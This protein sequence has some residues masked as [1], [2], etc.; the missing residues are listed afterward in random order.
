MSEGAV[1][2]SSSMNFWARPALVAA[3][4]SGLALSSPH[5]P[6]PPAFADPLL[7]FLVVAVVLGATSGPRDGVRPAVLAVLVVC[8]AV[9]LAVVDR[10][11]LA[12][13]TL[14]LQTLALLVGARAIGRAVGE[15]IASAGHVLPAAIIAAAADVASVL[16][17]EGPTAQIVASERAVSL[18]VLAV[19]VPGTAEIAPLLGVGDVVF[20]ALLFGVVAR[21]ELS[22]VRTAVASALGVLA[23]FGLSLATASAVPALPTIGAAALL[24]EPRFRTLAPRDRRTAWIGI[25]L[26]IFV[27]AVVALRAKLSSG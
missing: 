27:V 14:A 21:H 9:A 25:G 2:G 4:A 26:A 19:P 8:A 24:F 6:V 18:L 12:T 10:V 1:S 23:A 22:A 11:G 16:S 17:P 3:L 5:V 13:W 20:V 15:R 7:P